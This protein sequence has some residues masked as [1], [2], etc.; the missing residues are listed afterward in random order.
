MV[1]LLLGALAAGAVFA[2]VFVLPRF[3]GTPPSIRAPERVAMGGEPARVEI[4]LEDEGAG[5]RSVEVVLRHGDSERSLLKKPFPGTLNRGGT[6]GSERAELEVELDPAALGLPD[7]TAELE[8]RS[9]DWSLRDGFAGNLGVAV[10]ALEIDTRPPV[11]Q[12][13]S[14]LTYVARGGSATAVYRLD[15]EAER[16][17]VAVGD[18]FFPGHPADPGGDPRLRVAHFAVPVEAEIDPPIH[19][20]A[21]DD[22]G[23]EGRADLAARVLEKRFAQGRVRL[24]DRFLEQRALPLAEAN[25]LDTSDPVEA[26]RAVN[27]ELRQR[28]EAKIRE[29]VATSSDERQWEGAFVQW[30]NSAVTSRFAEKRS[31]EVGGRAVSEARHYGYDLAATARQ[32]VTAANSGTVAFAGDLGIYGNCVILDHG[33]GIASLYGHLSQIDVAEGDRVAKGDAVGRSGATGLAGGD[34]LHFA[35]LVGGEYV[36]PLEW[37][38]PKWVR[39]HVEDRLASVPRTPAVS[40]GAP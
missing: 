20:V 28:N 8:I 19:L 15:E 5:L 39:S 30:P 32:P 33:Q 38:D 16:D 40:A 22:A 26:F 29:V 7:G 23:N 31:Y 36:D 35:I 17:G 18:V 3:E 34:H 6:R 24:P 9:R 12:A 14:G 10:V 2:V 1:V 11:V 21:R 37:W 4:A 27:T 13:I 25:G